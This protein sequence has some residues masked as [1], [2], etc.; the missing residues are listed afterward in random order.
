MP[1]SR[2]R[3]LQV[4]PLGCATTLL[5]ACAPAAGVPAAPPTSPPP[6]ATSV[7][8]V[9][10]ASAPPTPTGVLPTAAAARPAATAAPAKSSVLPS[11]IALASKPAPDYPSKGEL[12]EDGYSKYPANPVRA[13]PAE[14]PGLGSTV[15]VFADGL[16]PPPTPLEQNPA[17]QAINKQLNAM[18]QFNVVPPA[19]YASKLAT[20]MAGGD[21]PDLISLF[22]G[23]IA[24]PNLPSFLQQA[25]ADLTPYL[26]GDA[27]KAYPNLAALPTFA[28]RNSGSLIG[29]HLWTVP[30]SRPSISSLMIKNSSVWDQ[31]IGPDY[32]PTNVDD[33]KRVLLQLN[34]PSAN[35]WAIGTFQAA[36]SGPFEI[37]WFASLFDAPNN[38]RLE[39][40]GKL[41]KDY[42]TPEYKEAVGYVRD[43]ISAGVFFPDSLTTTSAPA[44]MT[45]LVSGKCVLSVRS[46]GLDWTDGYQQGQHL[47]PPQT[48][49]FMRH[50]A[51]HDGAKPVFFLGTGY[52][53]NTMLKQASPERIKELLSILNW[54]AAP[55]GSQEDMLMTYGVEGTN[56]TVDSSGNPV[57]RDSWAGDAYNAAWRYM[58]QHPQVIYNATYPEFTRIVADAEAALI[59]IGVSDATLGYYSPTNNAKGV[60]LRLTFNDGLLEILQGSRP[61]GELDQLVSDWQANG[62]EDIRKEYLAAIAAAA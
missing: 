48:F 53:A 57:T 20:L 4:V 10:T 17:W 43:L 18:V 29:G 33:F 44:A 56:Y 12:Y 8:T 49:G 31:E 23:L 5:A 39:P 27:V 7:P 2:R 54:T 15:T 47:D 41:V 6:P 16:Y 25:A 28:W 32:T 36:L 38:W 46:L 30:I 62:G 35:R 52:A 34:Q 22:G 42:E 51:A 3:F 58:S 55:F 37:A 61:L 19:D 13:T 50:F 40:G 45:N 9:A 14:P 21:Y 59:P 1:S 11:Y 24:A 26:S 60:R